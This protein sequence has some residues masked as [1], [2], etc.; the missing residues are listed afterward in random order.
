MPNAVAEAV[1]ITDPT[2]PTQTS[3]NAA[4]LHFGSVGD[5]Y[6]HVPSKDESPVSS[7][8]GSHGHGAVSFATNGPH[9]HGVFSAQPHHPWHEAA[10]RNAGVNVANHTQ[11]QHRTAEVL[12]VNSDTHMSEDPVSADHTV[13]PARVP[14]PHPSVPPH[15]L[16]P[17][18]RSDGNPSTINQVPKADFIPGR[19]A[20]DNTRV[21]EADDDVIELTSSS[22][23]D[24]AKPLQRG[25]SVYQGRATRSRIKSG[26]TAPRPARTR[27][28][29]EKAAIAAAL[30]ADSSNTAHQ[31][32][33]STTSR[34]RPRPRPRARKTP[35]SK[36][37]VSSED[38]ETI[39]ATLSTLPVAGTPPA[40]VA[41]SI[42]R[43]ALL[44][45]ALS[46]GS[47]DRKRGRGDGLDSPPN[48]EE[49]TRPTKKPS[50]EEDSDL[51]SSSDLPELASILGGLVT[52][53]KKS[54]EAK[55]ILM[56][57]LNGLYRSSKRW[58]TG[59]LDLE[60]EEDDSLDPVENVL[61][62]EERGDRCDDED[63]TADAGEGG[64]D[65]YDLNDPFI[66]DSELMEKPKRRG[67]SRKNSTLATHEGDTAKD[68]EHVDI[69]APMPG[70]ELEDFARQRAEEVGRQIEED[71]HIA[72]A[73]ARNA[74]FREAAQSAEVM[75]DV[76]GLPNTGPRR[77]TAEDQYGVEYYR[78]Q[79][80]EAI[81][82]SRESSAQSLWQS[83]QRSPNDDAIGPGEATAKTT[84]LAGPIPSTP[85]ASSHFSSSGG[86]L[87]PLSTPPPNTPLS[88]HLASVPHT[89]SPSS[90]GWDHRLSLQTP[91]TKQL[92][93]PPFTANAGG[94]ST[95]SPTKAKPRPAIES[96]SPSTS[97]DISSAPSASQKTGYTVP[98]RRFGNMGNVDGT[99]A[100]DVS[101][102]GAP[103]MRFTF[104][105]RDEVN[106]PALQDELLARYYEHLPRLR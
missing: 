59:F 52:R 21:M 25:D 10:M 72:T 64:P 65:E 88:N 32:S 105:E 56:K 31:P 93:T 91:I 95:P 41:S 40:D 63:V 42:E 14:A 94:S 39:P 34:L 27:K 75:M 82:R 96:A 103:R 73:I 28:M 6:V 84:A 61:A 79:L 37:L 17:Y 22:E 50:V 38:D 18:S 77:S 23:D 87:H 47:P 53:D 13:E 12:K 71:R 11:D 8:L 90:S 55:K 43:T 49:D 101:S 16:V 3:V 5:L 24:G 44:P 76:E 80:E 83:T 69:D 36:V 60:A 67:K 57:K 98:R 104:P 9:Q 97:G 30:N 51:I 45:S 19:T 85:S 81:R 62:D 35:K 29:T 100:E 68:S 58:R 15:C 86:T 54:K 106:D 66:D 78:R 4:N 89:P 48:G 33:S 74:A 20:G 70:F 2:R 26:A 1:T 102:N 99:R 46:N 7:N 92:P